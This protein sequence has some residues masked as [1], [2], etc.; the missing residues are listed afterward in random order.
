MAATHWSQISNNALLC[1]PL[2]CL[3]SPTESMSCRLW[4][5]LHF[6]ELQASRRAV[7]G[8]YAAAAM[9][10]VPV[11]LSHFPGCLLTSYMTE[12]RPAPLISCWD[13]Q[14]RMMG[15]IPTQCSRFTLLSFPISLFVSQFVLQSVFFVVRLFFIVLFAY[16]HSLYMIISETCLDSILRHHKCVTAG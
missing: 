1:A 11:M 13:S 3:L 14:Q 8:Q 4:S 6:S 12:S 9:R 5:L 16:I 10:N 15:G 7:V 2:V